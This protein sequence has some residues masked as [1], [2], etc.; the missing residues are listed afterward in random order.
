[1]DELKTSIEQLYR[2]FADYPLGGPVEGC[3]CC[4]DAEDKQSL[5]SAPLRELTAQSLNHYSRKAMTTWGGVHEFKHFLPRIFELALC[6]RDLETDIEVVMGKL[7]CA[8]WRNWPDGEREAVCAY[9]MTSWKGVV[10]GSVT[11]IE[12]TEWLCGVGIAG[13]NL[14]PYFEIWMN[15]KT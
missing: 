3:P 13:E 14:T 4:V 7:E 15:A 5:V 12:P 6:G 1:M 9:L 11:Y 2:V 10:S 8:E